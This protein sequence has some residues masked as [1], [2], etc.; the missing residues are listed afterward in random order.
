MTLAWCKGAFK[1]ASSVAFQFHRNKTSK[2]SA[3]NLW[4]SNYLP[5]CARVSIKSCCRHSDTSRA[6]ILGCLS[7]C[8]GFIIVDLS[9]KT[10]FQWS[11]FLFVQPTRPCNKEVLW[12]KKNPNKTM[13]KTIWKFM[14]LVRTETIISR[15]P[16]VCPALFAC[17]TFQKSAF[18][19]VETH[20]HMTCRLWHAKFSLYTF[21]CQKMKKR[22]TECVQW[23]S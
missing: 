19:L 9:T 23:F 21:L 10:G 3:K 16:C 1:L 13:R 20:M 18:F 17:K 7:F 8:C 4:K 5:E 2:I 12:R 15:F 14:S 22:N 11:C 6:Y